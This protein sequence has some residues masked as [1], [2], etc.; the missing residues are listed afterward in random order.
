MSL[1]LFLMTYVD[2]VSENLSFKKPNTMDNVQ[3]NRHVYC[4]THL[5]TQFDIIQILT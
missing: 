4:K 2:A 3:N 1:S 5:V